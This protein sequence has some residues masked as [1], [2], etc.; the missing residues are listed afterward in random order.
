MF[1]LLPDFFKNEEELKELWSAPQTRRALLEKLA[2]AG[3]GKE[4]LE[5]I[6]K[7]INAEKSDLFD[8]LEYIVFAHRP[9][10]RERRVAESKENIYYGLDDKQREFVEFVLS[11]YIETGVGELDQEKLPYLL[12]LK[13]HAIPDAVAVLGSTDKILSTFIDFQKH[14]Y[15][16]KGV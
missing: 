14:M 6:Q 11:K 8:V 5:S 3:Y 15:W 12:L 7:L 4:Q 13:Y 9:I 2:D 10:T 16:S 1:G